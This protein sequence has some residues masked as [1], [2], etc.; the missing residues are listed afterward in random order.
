MKEFY[1]LYYY[2][3]RQ[4]VAADSH[5]IYDELY[6]IDPFLDD[7]SSKKEMKKRKPSIITN[8]CLNPKGLRSENDKN[9]R[10]IVNSIP[11]SPRSSF[12]FYDRNRRRSVKTTKKMG[13]KNWSKLENKYIS[14]M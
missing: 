6:I 2:L 11:D 10:V 7:S 8:I 1:H 13:A 14:Y 9:D 4:I 12:E 3:S 5:I